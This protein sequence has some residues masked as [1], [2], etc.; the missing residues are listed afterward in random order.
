MLIP[1]ATLNYW[2][3]RFVLAGGA[4]LM[5]FEQFMALPLAVRERRLEHLQAID[6]HDL[7]ERLERALPDAAWHGPVF[8][9]PFHHGVRRGR[10]AWFRNDRNHV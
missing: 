8:I 1:D 2:A 6:S 4:A 10:H 3:E 5:P 7:Q 9:D